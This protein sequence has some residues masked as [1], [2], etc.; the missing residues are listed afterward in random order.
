MP[1]QI[2]SEQFSGPLELLLQLIEQEEL[3]IT[4]VSL[5]QVAEQYLR[6][7]QASPQIH[8]DELA[9]FLVIAARLLLLKSKVLLP[10]LELPDEGPDL[11][12]Q[13]KLYKEF[14]T[15]AKG[16]EQMI[17][18]GRY[19]YAREKLPSGVLPEFSPPPGLTVER[20]AELFG[21]VLEHVRPLVELPQ[22]TLERVVSI[23]EKIAHIRDRLVNA[24]KTSF[25]QLVGRGDKAEA[26]VSFLALLE[27]M[28]QRHVTL[29]QDELFSDITIHRS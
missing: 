29:H 14:A 11:A 13:L 18:Q 26:I 25:R 8:P 17:G 28:K 15:A 5:A 27:L 20:L 24:V 6:Y 12:T 16:I 22:K 4:K 3:D 21:N 7:V 19:S 23:E 9:D 10:N 2:E 1:Y